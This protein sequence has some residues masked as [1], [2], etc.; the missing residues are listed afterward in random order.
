M[1]AP[2]TQGP[3]LPKSRPLADKAPEPEVTYEITFE[4][5]DDREQYGTL[6]LDEYIPED[7]YGR[8]L[9]SKRVYAFD[10]H[11][12]TPEEQYLAQYET[13][14]R[15]IEERTAKATAKK[16]LLDIA[17]TGGHYSG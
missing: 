2:R 4:W 17:R 13:L 14:L 12:L 16:N 7:G 9:M 10:R 6:N 11:D 5:E 3:W 8:R 1:Y 15:N